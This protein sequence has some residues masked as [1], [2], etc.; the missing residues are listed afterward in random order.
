MLD[1]YAI[2]SQWAKFTNFDPDQKAFNL[3]SAEHSFHCC[4][5]RIMALNEAFDPSGALSVIFAKNTC[6]KYFQDKKLSLLEI[7]NNPN[8]LKNALDIWQLFNSPDVVAVEDAYLDAMDKLITQITGTK[9]LGHVDNDSNRE[10][11]MV[12]VDKVVEELDGCHEDLFRL[13]GEVQAATRFS[14]HIHVFEQLSEC[15]LA[16]ETTQDGIYLCYISAEN[17]ADGYFGFYLKSNGNLLSVNERVNEA[18]AGQHKNSRNGRW[19]EGKKYQLFPYDFIF[20]FSEHDY[21]G[22]AKKHII[23][24][25]KL[26]F[27]EL[28]PDAYFPL[29]LAMVML[30]TKYTGRKLD[31]M[32]IKM[33]DSLLDVNLRE[34]M[35]DRKS[36]V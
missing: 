3:R 23:D 25:E 36:V 6:R 10:T 32:P 9:M 26:S 13:G 5:K 12:A 8:E 24:V 33:V 17:S 22:Y 16:M 21:K 15:L 18:F 30:N 4:N 34:A 20:N 29:V 27:F 7:A 2:L 11:L 35:P 14:T 1:S 28:G 31:S 19:S